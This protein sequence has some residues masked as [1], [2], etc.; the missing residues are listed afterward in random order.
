[1]K[2]TLDRAPAA[3]ILSVKA[4]LCMLVVP[5]IAFQQIKTKLSPILL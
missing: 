2:M 1:M 5:L 4:V 3:V